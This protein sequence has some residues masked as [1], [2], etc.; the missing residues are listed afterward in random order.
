MAHIKIDGDRWKVRLGQDRPKPGVRLVLFFCEPTGQ[1]PYRVV[2][3]GEDR[4]TSQADIEKLSSKE[5]IDLYRQSTSMD[6][7][8]YRSDEVTDVR[9]DR[10]G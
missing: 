4:F 10:R 2:E 3:V 8:V 9:R 6:L 1:R 7:P 5:L